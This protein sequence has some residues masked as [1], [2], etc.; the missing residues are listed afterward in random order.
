GE[1]KVPGA[2]R[3]L[4]LYVHYDGQPVDPSH[5]SGTLPF[6]PVLRPGKLKK[7]GTNDPKPMPF[8]KAGQTFNENWRL[9][10]RSTSDDKAPLIGI[11]TALD[12]IKHA[13]IPLKNNLKF[14][15]EG[16]EEAGSPNLGGFLQ[17]HKDLLKADVLLMCDGPAYFSGATT[18][19]FGVR[20]VTTIEIEI[21]GAYASLHSGHY[22]NW[23]PNPGML[24]SQLLASMKDAKGNVLVK[25]FYDTVTPLSPLEIKTI[26]EIPGYE[27][28]LKKQYGFHTE[29][30]P[31]LSL[32]EAIQRPSLNI[33][34]LRSG[35]VGSQARTIIP[36]DAE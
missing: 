6:N 15:F 11:M 12:A 26:K 18:L 20:G 29:E 30:N 25:G 24:L 32:M 3:T 23:A 10:G 17:K 2:T 13:K 1:I 14:I 27:K 31:D 5:W 34:G 8:P 36:P 19:F 21:Y 4:L 9:Y 33:A 7:A 35:W 16:E 22:G 28:K